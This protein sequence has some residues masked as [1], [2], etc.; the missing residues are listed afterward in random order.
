MGLKA[1]QGQPRRGGAARTQL[2]EANGS[3]GPLDCQH[4]D[5]GYRGPSHGPR[6]PLRGACIS[7]ESQHGGCRWRAWRGSDE[8]SF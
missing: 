1:E 6:W 3:G 2:S 7:C 8:A 4:P 5:R